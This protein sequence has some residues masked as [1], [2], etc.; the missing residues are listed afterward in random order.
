MLLRT[1]RLAGLEEEKPKLMSSMRRV[2]ERVPSDR[3][4]SS[5]VLPSLAVR[6]MRLP[7]TEMLGGEVAEG[8]CRVKRNGVVPL[9]VPLDR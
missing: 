1:V 6:K 5:P 4:S 9:E 3:Q 7:M 8:I 2:P